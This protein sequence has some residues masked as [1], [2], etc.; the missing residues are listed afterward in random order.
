MRVVCPGSYDPV[1]NGHVD[2]FLRAAR[3]FDEVIVAVVHNPSKPAGMFTIPERFAFLEEALAGRA[4]NIRLDE[5]PGGLLADYCRRVEAPA[6][7]KGLRSGT[8]YEYE[9]RMEMMNRHLTG[10]ETLYISGDAALAHV[11][12]SLVKEVA[13]NGGDVSALVPPVVARALAAKAS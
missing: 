4:D 9:R 7:I 13:V 10:L 2:V 11:S 5:V 1:T 6:V 12:S 8:D 3:L